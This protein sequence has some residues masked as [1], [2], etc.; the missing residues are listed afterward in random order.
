MV[1]ARMYHV[2]VYVSM[3]ASSGGLY[4]MGAIVSKVV[5]CFR[6]M[7]FKVIR[8]SHVGRDLIVSPQAACRD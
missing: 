3:D 7:A 4:V 8:L 6:V 1:E 5:A 2:H